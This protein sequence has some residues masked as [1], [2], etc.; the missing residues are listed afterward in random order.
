MGKIVKYCAACDESFAEKFGYCP[1]CGQVM[2]AFEMNPVTQSPVTEEP[3]TEIKTAPVSEKI[4]ESVVGQPVFRSSAP[5]FDK[6]QAATPVA[7]A[8]IAETPTETFIETP[9]EEFTPEEAPIVPKTFAAAAGAN[10][11][12]NGNYQQTAKLDSKSS[13][14]APDDDDFHV[15]VIEEK[16]AGQRNKLLLGTMAIMLAL[17][18]G[19]TVYSLF[20][21]D[22]GVGAI[23]DE[24]LFALVRC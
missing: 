6:T 24:S 2:T 19:S 10:A 8:P 22:L 11:N 13:H 1:N 3:A 5:T 15:T 23:G 4:E 17:V 18:T 20:N 14:I 21:K 16:N 9:T 7:A 12:D